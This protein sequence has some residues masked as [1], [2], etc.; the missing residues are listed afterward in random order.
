MSVSFTPGKALQPIFMV[1]EHWRPDTGVCFYVGKGQAN[2]A[3]QMYKRNSYHRG[4]QKKL[5]ALGLDVE[6]RIICEGMIERDALVLERE[7]IALYPNGQLTNL[8]IGGDG[9]SGYKHMPEHIEKARA[10][11]TGNKYNLGK[12]RPSLQTSERCRQARL[13]QSVPPILG[14]RFTPEQKAKLAV[15]GTKRFSGHKHSDEAKERMRLAG[16][17]RK[18]PMTAATKAKLSAARKGKKRTPEQLAAFRARYKEIV[19]LRRMARAIADYDFGR[20]AM[21]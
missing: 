16:I 11:A 4:I 6:I 8:T 12:K 3:R 14:Y 17:G 19:L 21:I 20:G 7:R 18:N 15:S 10:R 1:Y 9:C 13:K 5:K 2:R